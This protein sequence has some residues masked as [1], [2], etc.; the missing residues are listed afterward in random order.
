MTEEQ[1]DRLFTRENLRLFQPGPGEDGLMPMVAGHTF[2][3]V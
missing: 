1:F 3:N 2:A